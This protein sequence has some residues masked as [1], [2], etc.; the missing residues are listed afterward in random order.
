M[1][2]IMERRTRPAAPSGRPRSPWAWAAAG[3]LLGGAVTLLWHAPADW[4]ASAVHRATAGRVVL[5]EARG[6]V[7]TGSARL[8][9]TGGQGSQNPSALPGRMDWRIR[10]AWPGLSVRLG[11]GCCTAEPVALAIAPRWGGARVQVLDSPSGPARPTVWPSAV[12]AGLGAPWNTLQV[13]GQL[14]LRT[15]GLSVEWIEGR[16]SVA[17]S[18]ELIATGMSSRLSTLKPMGSY[19]ITLNGGNP[20]ALELATLDGS[21]QLAGTGQWVGSRFRFRGMAT[22]APEREAALSN[23]L[24]IIGRRNGARSIITV[25]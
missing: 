16:M 18:A 24:N 6:T 19:R 21:L 3:A 8:V 5:A 12:L 2:P 11:A 1:T 13:E 9:L 4:L 25:G 20:A 10:P 14:S 22:A 23:L 17:G 7:W 15:R